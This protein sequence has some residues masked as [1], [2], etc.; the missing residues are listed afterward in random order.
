MIDVKNF[1]E[2]MILE[3]N[4]PLTDNALAYERNLLRRVY[5]GLENKEILAGTSV[6][7][8]DNDTVEVLLVSYNHKLLHRAQ[9]IVLD[10]IDPGWRVLTDVLPRHYVWRGEEPLRQIRLH[11]IPTVDGTLQIVKLREPNNTEGHS[12]ARWH[13]VY[14]A[15]GALG[16]LST[17]DTLRAR[18]AV[19]KITTELR[20]L[21]Y[22]PQQSTDYRGGRR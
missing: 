7:A 10:S 8:L 19:E 12:V 15:L 5:G 20:K 21:I 6:I 16:R 2:T 13:D 9:E 22:E 14:V 18:P 11:P 17:I 3:A 4:Y 1:V